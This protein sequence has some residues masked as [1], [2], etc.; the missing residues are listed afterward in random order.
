MKKSCLLLFVP[1]LIASCKAQKNKPPLATATNENTVL[2]KISGKGI[3]TSYLLG[4]MHLLCAED[5]VLSDNL[6]TVLKIVDQIY[7]E[8]D[9]DNMADIMGAVTKMSM[10]N[11]VKLKDLLTEEEYKKVKDFFSKKNSMLP[12]SM[13]ENFKP[14]LVASTLTEEEMPCKNGVSGI[15]MRIMETNKKD[16]KKEILGLETIAMQL[17]IFDSIPYKEQAKMLLGYVDSLPKTLNET[18]KL[19]EVYKSQNLKKIE[20]LMNKSEPGL[21]GYMD[22]LLVNRNKNWVKQ[23]NTICKSKS[24][25]AAVGAGHLVGVNGVLTLLKKEGYTVTPLKN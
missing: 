25:L 19:V 16:G 2:W 21:E 22:L 24:I 10:A 3:K 12:F 15:E 13:M 11:G 4:T 6:K 7:M 1:F 20:A 17:A 5:A 18:A 9:M 8:L 14:M 23:L